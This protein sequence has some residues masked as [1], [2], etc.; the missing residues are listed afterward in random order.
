M[1]GRA[2]TSLDGFP[3]KYARI[4]IRDPNRKK[5]FAS[6]QPTAAVGT[7]LAA[8]FREFWLMRKAKTP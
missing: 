7:T 4:R 6:L 2:M 3:A 1:G 5:D 8:R